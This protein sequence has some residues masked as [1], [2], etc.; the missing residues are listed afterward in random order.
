MRGTRWLLLVAIVL[1]VGGIAATYRAQRKALR[2]SAP[3]KPESLSTDLNSSAKNWHWVQTDLKP[4]FRKIVEMEAE[5]FAQLKG[6]DRVDLQRVQLKIYHKDDEAFDLVKSAAA[7]FFRQENRLYSEGEVEITLG[8]PTNGPPPHGLVSI[9]SSGVNFDSNTGRSETDRPSTF[10]F[11]QGDGKATGAIYDPTTRRLEMKSAVEIHWQSPGPH[12]KPMKIEAGSL[13][14]FETKSEI[15]LSPWGR[16]TRDNSVVEGQNAVIHLQEGRTIRLVEARNAHGT[17]SFPKRKLQYQADQL[18]V[19][20]NDDG[21]VSNV[22][23]QTNARMVSDGEASQTTVTAN[24]VQMEFAT[25]SGES[26]LRKVVTTGNSQVEARPKPLPGRTLPESQILRSDAI[27]MTMRADGKEMDRVV[28]RS[29]GS[30]EFL[31]NLPVQHHRRMEGQTMTIV[32]GP[33]NQID[34]FDSTGVKTVTD[35][36]AAE[37]K[38]NRGVAVTT[39]KELRAKFEPKSSRLATMEQWGD[40]TYEEG[41]RHARSVKASLDSAQNIMRLEMAARIWDPSG[42]TAADRIRMDQR[43]GDYTAEGHVSSSRLPEQ[44]KKK[45]SGMLSGDEPLQAQAQKMDSANRNRVIHYQGKVTMWQGANRIQAEA[46][47]INREKHTLV[48]DGNVVSQL[49][50]QPKD[51]AP[52]AA[53]K[54]QAGTARHSAQTKKKAPANPV[55]TVVRAPRLTYSDESRLAY[56]SGGVHLRRPGLE[57]KSRELRAWLADSDAD[58]SLDH[59]FADGNVLMVLTGP[60]WTRTG[61]GEHGEYY[62]DDQ[63]VIMRGKPALLVDSQGRRT[64]GDELTYFSNDDRLLVNGAPE[65]RTDSVLPKKKKK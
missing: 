40:F 12:A 17:D 7:S 62:E 37:K 2:H 49:W 50:A 16:V 39:S 45:G 33:D 44:G 64:R 19:D 43:T 5:N 51:D 8:V 56:Y 54:P 24:K 9:K 4:P 61:T 34:T 32:Y 14:Y 36:T 1:I 58:S 21:Q 60:L 27:D 30:L 42:S 31:P 57:V 25:G 55:L 6:V 35:P 11:A 53:G 29:P 18:W 63:K 41:D 3:G 15:W 13:N 38:R 46:V 28:T 47:D 10:I 26:V 52:E 20:F 59:A 48:A 65:R 23:A 22:L